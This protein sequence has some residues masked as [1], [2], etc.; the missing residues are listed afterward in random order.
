[1]REAPLPVGANDQSEVV[2]REDHLVSGGT[3]TDLQDEHVVLGAVLE[4]VSRSVRREAG[5]H[6]RGEL[7]FDTVGDEC[8]VALEDVEEFV[9]QAMTVGERRGVSRGQP[10]EVD[11]E[12]L[13]GEVVTERVFHSPRQQRREWFRQVEST[14]AGR[15]GGSLDGDGWSRW[16][17]HAAL[18]DGMTGKR[19]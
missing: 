15:Y 9:L 2:D 8:R 10:C 14:G 12:S 17:T 7:H 16:L 6:A 19:G 11:P 18:L 4:V 5:A 1:V 13:Q 3:V